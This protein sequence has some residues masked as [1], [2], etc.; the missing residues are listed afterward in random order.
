MLVREDICSG[1][2]A[3]LEKDKN[4]GNALH[5]DFR[6]KD[7]VNISVNCPKFSSWS[8]IPGFILFKYF[9][10]DFILAVV[11]SLIDIEHCPS[12]NPQHFIGI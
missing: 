6:V 11:T 9:N 3:T 8:I 12:L 10:C 4:M 7:P 1:I 2:A 5:L